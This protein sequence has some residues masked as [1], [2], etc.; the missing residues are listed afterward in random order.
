MAQDN[1][2]SD[3]GG[4]RRTMKTAEIVALDIV[5]DIVGRQ[6]KPG[7][8]L[9]LEAELLVQYGV[10]RSSLREALRLLETQ[11][12]I[13]IRPGPGAGT[14]V[15]EPSPRNLGR[16]M[17]LY[18]HLANVSYDELL[19]TWVLTE[20]LL[21]ELAAQNPDKARRTELM[22]PYLG[23]TREGETIAISS[24]LSFHDA[25]AELA[26]NKALSITYRAI[27][28]IVS[29]HMLVHKD[30]TALEPFIIDEHADLARAII[31]G[32]A[33]KAGKLMRDHVQHVSDDFTAYWPRKVG[34]R[35]LW[36]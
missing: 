4:P 3:P 25:V 32:N 31:D 34:E 2:H 24:G 16:T 18:F 22:S 26:D 11:G 21:A 35:V 28:F 9:P 8:R 1:G 7:D 14:I 33:K 36:R 20:P 13:K 6:L 23:S 12:L 5:R 10:S 19:R 17:T 30:R 29:D 15:A 27:G